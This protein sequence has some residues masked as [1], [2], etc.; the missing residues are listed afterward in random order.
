MVLSI[1]KPLTLYLFLLFYSWQDSH[2]EVKGDIFVS[3]IS[4]IKR[5]PESSS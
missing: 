3:P 2:L 5:G 4:L 1:F